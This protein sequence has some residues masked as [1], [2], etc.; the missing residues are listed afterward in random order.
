VRAGRACFTAGVACGL[1]LGACTDFR[2]PYA[3]GRV[4]AGETVLGGRIE[5]VPPLAADE[6]DISGI[7][8]TDVENRVFLLVDDHP[9]V[10]EGD[11]ETGD[12]EDGI[13]ATLGEPFWV[14]VPARPLHVLRASIVMRTAPAVEMAHLPGGMVVDIQPGD[15]AVYMGTIRY[16]RDEFFTVRRVEV[17]D[18]YAAASADYQS[19]A[20]SDV[21]L[22]RRLVRP[23]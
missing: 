14:T 15:R 6:Q 18:E 4:A 13:A 5:L 11:P 17:I 7:Q 9:R 2:D 10:I 22:T 16:T 21:P 19:R 3:G 8:T 1:G 12:F 20:A 23:L